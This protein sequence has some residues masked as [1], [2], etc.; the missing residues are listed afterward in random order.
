MALPI[1]DI[2]T[3]H[4]IVA[5]MFIQEANKPKDKIDFTEQLKACRKILDKS[6]L[7]L[8]NQ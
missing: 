2:P 4:G 3:L 7:H 8:N 5:K 6:K 1:R